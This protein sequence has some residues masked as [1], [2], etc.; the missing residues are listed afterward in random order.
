MN[1]YLPDNSPARLGVL[2]I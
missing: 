1:F 2:F